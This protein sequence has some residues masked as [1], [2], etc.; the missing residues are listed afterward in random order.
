MLGAAE[1]MEWSYLVAT[2]HGAVV[3]ERSALHLLRRAWINID[4]VWAGS[5]VL[6]AA[7]VLTL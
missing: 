4:V 5:L 3:Y 1:L 6:T 7:A 2:A